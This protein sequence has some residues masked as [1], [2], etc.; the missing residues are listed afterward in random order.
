MSEN[1]FT[2][3]N[4]NYTMGFCLLTERCEYIPKY[5]T[6]GCSSCE[7]NP[8]NY[9]EETNSPCLSELI[10]K[11]KEKETE[12]QVEKEYL[13]KLVNDHWNYIEGV[14]Y[15][16]IQYDEATEIDVARIEEIGFHY[17]TAF[18]HGYGHAREYHV[19]DTL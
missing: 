8:D 15:A 7:N 14:L 10:K 1:C 6:K 4:Y 9:K 5:T 19:G 11:A 12:K 2:C 17:K 16:A 18:K 3:R 13:D